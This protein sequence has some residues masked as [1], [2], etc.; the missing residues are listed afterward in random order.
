MI[1]P[2]ILREDSA[3]IKNC[4]SHRKIDFDLEK[5]L[6]WKKSFCKPKKKTKNC[7]SK[8]S[9]LSIYPK[10]IYRKKKKLKKLS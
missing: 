8:E 10:R 4:L 7:K 3:K 6:S 9:C 5:L 2:K 1:D